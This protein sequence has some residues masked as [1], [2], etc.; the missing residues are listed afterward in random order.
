MFY[1]LSFIMR[2]TLE[3]KEAWRECAIEI[4]SKSGLGTGLL[5]RALGVGDGSGR[6]W[7]RWMAPA[8]PMPRK[9]FD[10]I[11]AALLR[12]WVS[13][14]TA[15]ALVGAA[16]GAAERLEKF[17]QRETERR[18]AAPIEPPALPFD[19][20][21]PAPA[22]EIAHLHKRAKQYGD[23]AF[24]CLVT[25][26]HSEMNSREAAWLLMRAAE[27]QAQRVGTRAALA[28]LQKD[29]QGAEWLH[30]AE[31]LKPLIGPTLKS[32]EMEQ[33]RPKG[34]PGRGRWRQR[35]ALLDALQAAYE[36]MGYPPPP[37]A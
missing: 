27:R 7:R 22:A 16:E 8:P 18:A 26:M 31:L 14:R 21:P 11:E 6:S 3:M 24:F 23:E 17:R 33:G 20:P 13:N 1:L 12:G 4:R 25:Q 36:R 37:A 28:G 5:E 15:Q 34:N 10:L 19:L 9:W 32:A 29:P 35:D 30:A 2:A